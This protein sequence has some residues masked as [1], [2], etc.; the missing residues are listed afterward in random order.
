MFRSGSLLGLAF[1]ALLAV[2]PPL[3]AKSNVHTYW[4]Q[5]HFMA[6]VED[7]SNRLQF[8]APHFAPVGSRPA[9]TDYTLTNINLNKL[10]INLSYNESG[11]N[12]VP[13]GLLGLT[14]ISVPYTKESVFSIVYAG[15]E[16]IEIR[17]YTA[18]SVA[19]WCAIPMGKDSGNG[20]I[21]V[22]SREDAERVAD[23]LATL[24]VAYGKNLSTSFSMALGVMTDK[25][26]RKHPGQ[27]GCKVRE[28]DEDGPAAQAGIQE[29]DIV[30]AINGLPCSLQTFSAAVTEAVVKPQG[31]V[32][33][34]EILRKSGPLTVDLHFP[35]PDVPAAQLRRQV[36]NPAQQYEPTPS[37]TPTPTAPPSSVHFGFQVRPVIQDDMAPLMLTKAEGLVVVSVE[38]GSLADTMGVL[39]GDVILTANGAEVG[40]MQHFSQ[41]IHAGAVTTFN[42]WRKG[43]TLV[44]T[45]P[46]SM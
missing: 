40:D 26:Q 24:A 36:A 25:E 28:V 3:F 38:N 39:A 45:V 18:G 9:T 44:L 46:Q 31:S 43:K 23:A 13:K 35:H 27:T 34:A 32:V 20:I 12:Q 1:V 8:L 19:P 37:A 16:F 10:G 22:S 7:A 2:P 42:V 14:S 11:V 17:N 21:C 5:P 41:L 6:S 30:H 29:D 33:H 4:Y 15:I